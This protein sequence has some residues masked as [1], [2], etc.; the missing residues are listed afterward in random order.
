[1]SETARE[2][3][4]S[5]ITDLSHFIM[6]Q[7]ELTFNQQEGCAILKFNKPNIQCLNNLS[8][9]ILSAFTLIPKDKDEK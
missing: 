5:K 4:E 7:A 3:L 1:M 2:E 9:A 6:T 8:R